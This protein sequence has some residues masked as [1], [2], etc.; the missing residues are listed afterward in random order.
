MEYLP[1]FLKIRGRPALVVGGGTVALRKVQWLCRA[2]ARVTVVA[3]ECVDEL[4][5]LARSRE[6]TLHL[7][8]FAP[9]DI[10]QCTLAVAAT[11]NVVLNRAIHR[12]A[13]ASGVP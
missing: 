4:R 2:G 6:I 8:P 1:I 5:D 7:R 10:A 3:P 11:G 13:T 9:G 12:L